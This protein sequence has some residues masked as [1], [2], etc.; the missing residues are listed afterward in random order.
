MAAQTTLELFHTNEWE[1]GGQDSV[2]PQEGV[3]DVLGSMSSTPG[4]FK[5]LT[6]FSTEEF[7]NLCQIVCPTISTHAR[8]TGDLRVLPGRPS[9]LNPEQRLLGFLLY[10]KHDPTTALPSFLWNWGKSSIIDDQIFIA[11]SI[12]WALRDEIRWPNVQERQAL[13]SMIPSFPGCIGIIDGT[14]VKIR[15]PWKNPEH[16][17][18]FNGRKKMYCMNNVVIFNHNG[19]FIYV[20]PAYLGSFHD[21]SCLRAYDIYRV[22]CDYFTHDDA[23]QYFEY[24]LGHSGHVGTKMF[25]LCRIQGQEMGAE[26]AQPMVDA[27]NKMHV[28]YRI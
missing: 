28:G 25:I 27:W 5:T 20:D 19:L 17:K 3:R 6:N 22:W 8:S 24:V 15:R 1:H 16:G 23:N 13:A 18:W 2:N 7:D 11:S 12:N 21:V 9:K 4:L 14:L 26:V 10:M